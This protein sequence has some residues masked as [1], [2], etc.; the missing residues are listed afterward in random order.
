MIK[1][2]Q[3]LKKGTKLNLYD[4]V[5]LGQDKR[6]GV[7]VAKR[8]QQHSSHDAKANCHQP[9]YKETFVHMI[10]YEL[11]ILWYKLRQSVHM[12]RTQDKEDANIANA[13]PIFRT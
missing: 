11:P 10:T 12:Q 1:T 9:L 6:P 5:A 2:V 4:R 7:G 13:I 3:P 8:H